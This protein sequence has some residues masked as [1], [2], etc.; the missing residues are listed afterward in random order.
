MEESYRKYL[1]F[2]VWIDHDIFNLL[3]NHREITL[4]IAQDV[5][6]AR[7]DICQGKMYP[8]LSD[9][10]SIQ[11]VDKSAKQYLASEAGVLQLSAGAL[12][13]NNRFQKIIS[14]LFILTNKLAVPS[15]VFTNKPQAIIWLEQFKMAKQ[16]S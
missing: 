13:V 3:Y 16:V 6:K 14:N 11:H 5:V 12:L 7:L 15:K 9:I 10:R 8:M 4:K 2:E 1:H